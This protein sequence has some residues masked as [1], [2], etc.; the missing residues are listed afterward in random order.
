MDST[1]Q[2]G[3]CYW[4]TPDSLWVWR[5]PARTFIFVVWDFAITILDLRAFSKNKCNHLMIEIRTPRWPEGSVR[6]PVSYK[7]SSSLKSYSM[8]L[9]FVFACDE[10]SWNLGEHKR[11]SKDAVATSFPQ[12]QGSVGRPV[13]QDVTIN[14]STNFPIDLPVW[15]QA[16][17]AP[18]CFPLLQECKRFEQTFPTSSPLPP[19]GSWR[20]PPFEK[21]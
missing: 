6:L 5:N 9:A 21:N 19:S 11:F 1:G 15:P 8:P 20:K 16:G 17:P 4:I 2:H 7:P 18:H 3:T 12:A 10:I 13:R 14:E